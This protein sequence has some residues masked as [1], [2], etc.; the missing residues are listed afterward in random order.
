[1]GRLLDLFYNKYNYTDFH[2]LNLSWL[3]KAV[4]Q[5]LIEM[6]NMEEWKAQHI[7]EY[8]QLKKL[9]DDII[10]GNFPD[11]MKNS[12]YEW[13]E[14]NAMDIIG[15]L[16]KIVFFGITDDGYFVAYIPESWEDIIFGTSGLDDFPSGVEYGHL[17]LSFNIG[18]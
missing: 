7:E 5:L 1:M 11:E 10:S 9:Y 15:N 13:V 3:L 17:T 14:Q 8:E 2:E 12:L 16:V 18:G 6:D 4:K